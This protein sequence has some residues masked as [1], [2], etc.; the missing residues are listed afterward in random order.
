MSK[1]QAPLGHNIVFE[2][3]LDT[4]DLATSLNNHVFLMFL[5][6]RQ[7]P[8]MNPACL[9]NGSKM[10]PTM[11]PKVVPKWLRKWSQHRSCFWLLFGAHFGP[12][13]GPKWAQKGYQKGVRKGHQTN[14]CPRA[15][16]RRSR[17]PKWSQNGPQMG[18]KGVQKG[19]RKG[20]KIDKVA[21]PLKAK[22]RSKNSNV[23]Q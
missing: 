17:S 4:A 11:G 16:Q 8:G 6:C 9:Q 15:T 20:P 14:S 18:P 13:M 5:R 22:A 3:I 10:G 21:G 1:V 7:K 2:T 12:K 19:V 23:V